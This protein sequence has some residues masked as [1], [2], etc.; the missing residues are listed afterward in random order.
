M[1][2]SI[3]FFFAF[4]FLASVNGFSQNSTVTLP[5]DSIC[6]EQLFTEIEK[7]TDLKFLYQYENIA[8][9][10]AIIHADDMDVF[11]VLDEAL[12]T[13]RLRYSI[14]ENNLIVVALQ[15]RSIS[16][17]ITDA[18]N[19][20]PIPTATVFFANT[21]VGVTTD[22]DGNYQLK[23]PGEGIYNLMVSHV[24]YQP[25]VNSIM[26]GTTSIVM[27]VTMQIKELDEVNV[28]K[29]IRFRR[30]DI[31][32][33]WNKVLGR[34]PSKSTIQATNP[35]AVYYYYNPKTRLLKV[36]CHEP[37]QIINYETGYHIQY[38]LT[39]FVY[40]YNTKITNWDYNCAFTELEPENIRQQLYWEK[41]R[42]AVYH[43]SLTKL[44]K[45][46]YNNSLS[47]DG[48]VLLSNL[49]QSELFVP[50]NQSLSV[51]PDFMVLDNVAD[52][53]KTLDLLTD[54]MLLL[55][56]GRPVTDND[57]TNIA[58]IRSEVGGIQN[59]S[60]RRWNREF[61]GIYR[62]VLYGGGTIYIYSDGTFTY[63]LII[64]T[65]D[66]SKPKLEGLSMSVPIDFDPDAS[67]SS[68]TTTE[69]MGEE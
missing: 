19:G 61:N 22:M 3:L 41:N 12:K 42:K 7:Q 55:C 8:G 51:H 17:R 47:N 26:P 69:M 33:F 27:D 43:V 57:W 30:K 58:N 10:T 59:V 68:T 13:N 37:L 34:N 64:V 14:M 53:S 23:I 4:L 28:S 16:G 50:S 66:E 9:K 20:S 39:H 63:R 56:Y 2:L 35:E 11:V 1:K 60:S 5:M 25:V 48:F 45:S 44:I 62:N 18:R 52:N 31:N 24:G 6:L 49:R 15:T 38:F 29:R 67:L 40:D 36:T 46:L 32:L 21:T 65:M 54:E